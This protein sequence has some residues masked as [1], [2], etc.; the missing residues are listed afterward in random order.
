MQVTVFGAGGNVGQLAVEALLA[1][2]HSVVAFVHSHAPFTTTDTL[3]IFKGD[4]YDAQQVSDALAGSEVVI[5]ALGSWGTPRKDIQA[6]AMTNIVP[7]MKFHGIRRIISLTGHDARVVGDEVSLPHKLS[8]ALLDVIAGKVLH[9]GE[10]HI[11]LLQR[12]GLEWTVLRSPVM[13]Q[14]SSNDYRLSS[15]RPLPLS[16]IPRRA[17][18]KALVDQLEDTNYLRLSPFLTRT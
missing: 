12:S 2:Q 5:S 8:H 7:A 4:I 3:K 1:R 10:E 9:D 15:S 13:T 18:A 6:A 14:Q 11:R 17:V 16:T